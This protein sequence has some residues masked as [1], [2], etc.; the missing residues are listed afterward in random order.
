MKPTIPTLFLAATLA[1]SGLVTPQARADYFDMGT[2]YINAGMSMAAQEPM[3]R[4]IARDSERQID[5]DRRKTSSPRGVRHKSPTV[6]RAITTYRASRAVSQRV[7]TRLIALV[8]K[9][10]SPQTVA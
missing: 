4:Q 6:T 5:E 10:S 1:I 9:T 8:A 2:D 3:M 7:Q